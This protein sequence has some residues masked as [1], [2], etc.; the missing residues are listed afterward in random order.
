M[1]VTKSPPE[2]RTAGPSAEQ[3][4]GELVRQ[5]TQQMSELVRGEMRLA[6]AELKD[7]GKHAGTGAGLFGGAGIVA[8]YGVAAVITAI[9]AALA[10]VLPLWASAL[11]VGVVLL[12]VAGVLALVGRRQVTRAVP[13][14]PAQAMDSAR[15]DVEEI[16]GRARR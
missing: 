8:L 5:A 3:G 4:T 6:V 12:I 11:I 13:P 9:I 15:R 7:K 10:M 14:I 2:V 1:S 16:R